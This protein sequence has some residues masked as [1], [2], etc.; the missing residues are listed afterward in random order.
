MLWTKA[1]NRRNPRNPTKIWEPNTDSRICSSHF[2]NGFPSEENPIPTL[3][4]GYETIKKITPRKPPKTRMI[5]PDLDSPQP[6]K[7]KQDSHKTTVNNII[8]QHDIEAEADSTIVHHDHVY[9]DVDK[10]CSSCLDKDSQ[11]KYLKKQVQTLS[12]ELVKLNNIYQEKVKKP[13]GYNSILNDKDMKFHT[14]IPTIKAF[15]AIFNVIKP[16]ITHMKYWHSG[17]FVKFVCNPLRYKRSPKKTSRR[18]LTSKDE[19]LMTLMKIR[20]GTLNQE[21]ALKFGISKQTVSNIFT[22]WTKLLAKFLGTL[23]FNPPKDVVRQNLPPSFENLTYKYVRHIIDCTEIFLETPQNLSVRANTWSDYKHHNTAKY[24]ISITPAGMINFVSKGWGG[25]TSDKHITNH[26]G[27]LDIIEPFDKVLADRGFPIAED[28]ALLQA[29]LL[30]PPGRRGTAQ[31][32]KEEVKKTKQIANR[33]I[34]IEQAIRRMKYFRIL[35]NELPLTLL[36]HL[37][38]V[39]LV[40]AGICNLYPP[41][42]RYSK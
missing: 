35:K 24:F 40:V 10:G 37:D 33:R 22:T 13:F 15:D 3:L 26:C 9:V 29:E 31:F 30:V 6:K 4:L 7:Q 21:L 34:Y 17:T 38:D 28:L 12:Q 11:I 19:M 2:E 14:G 16:S 25:R 1:V 39:V 20:L 42:P 41:L 18:C 5:I 27:F 36:H 23:V 32:T 8:H